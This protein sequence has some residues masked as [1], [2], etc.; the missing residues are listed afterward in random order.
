MAN[1]VEYYEYNFIIQLPDDI[2]L[3]ATDLAQLNYEIE[4]SLNEIKNRK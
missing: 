3:E 4:Q 2:K 1:G